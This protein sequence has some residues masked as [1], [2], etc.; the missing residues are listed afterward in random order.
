MN[1]KVIAIRTK[2]VEE[3]I[4]QKVLLPGAAVW[5]LLVPSDWE[6]LTIPN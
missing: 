2:G 6:V 1:F 5:I 4:L 3:P